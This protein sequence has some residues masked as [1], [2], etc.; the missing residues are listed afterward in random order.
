[1]RG[2]G[3]VWKLKP[4]LKKTIWAGKG[5]DRRYGGKGTG[6]AYLLSD[7]PESSCL[8]TDGTPLYELRRRLGGDRPLSLLV[9]AIDAAEP[10][11]VQ[12]H[13]PRDGEG[14][15]KDELW[16]MDRV[17][18]HGEVSVGFRPGVTMEQCRRGCET[19]TVCSLLR[20]EKVS[21]GDVLL[22]PGGT[23]HWGKG[24][25]FYEIQHNCDVTYR[26]ADHGRGR[27]LQRAEAL[28]VLDPRA[29]LRRG[30]VDTLPLLSDGPET[31][32][33]LGIIDFRGGFCRAET[34]P[35]AFL[36]L[37]GS[38]TCCGE[39]FTVG[40]CFYAAGGARSLWE[41]R[42]RLLRLGSL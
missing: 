25:A 11:S 23:V 13:P 20:T 37:S 14:R 2:Y 35:C 15:G 31:P 1:M 7:R 38:G 5:L 17:S 39:A 22:I 29:E 34:E 6:E 30:R 36:V 4:Y 26:L 8:L 33:D 24:I 32:F 3:G 28:A 41:G 16:L 40:D 10:L 21:P 12:V 18:V 9:K 42:G 27:D 19:G